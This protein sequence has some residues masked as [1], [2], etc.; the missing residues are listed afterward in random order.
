MPVQLEHPFSQSPEPRRILIEPQ[1]PQQKHQK[2]RVRRRPSR[3]I[4]REISLRVL[5]AIS[6]P[7]LF[8][9]L[10]LRLSPNMEESMLP[11]LKGP[12]YLLLHDWTLGLGF[13]AGLAGAGY[14]AVA[15]RRVPATLLAG[16]LGIMLTNIVVAGLTSLLGLTL[17]PIKNNDMHDIGT[18]YAN[19]LLALVGPALFLFASWSGALG[20]S[21]R[22]AL[23]GAGLFALLTYTLYQIRDCFLVPKLWSEWHLMFPMALLVFVLP[24]TLLGGTSAL[25]ARISKKLLWLFSRA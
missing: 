2:K 16:V 5:G 11:F 13:F 8:C 17:T 4:V 10:Q 25:L 23:W 1:I 15:R 22:R 21:L 20:T 14:Q 19:Y 9:L 18:G 24:A 12:V 3:R 6:L 7:L